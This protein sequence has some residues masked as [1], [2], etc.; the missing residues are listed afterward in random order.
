MTTQ[1]STPFP[2]ADDITPAA[3]PV[4]PAATAARHAYESSV[5]DA[6]AA[7]EARATSEFDRH[8]ARRR[9]KVIA[10]WKAEN[11]WKCERPRYKYED[12]SP[13]AIFRDQLDPADRIPRLLEAGLY[14]QALRCFLVRA[15]GKATVE[16]CQHFL[17]PWMP[18]HGDRSIL[19]NDHERVDL[20]KHGRGDVHT[21]ADGLSPELVKLLSGS[22]LK[23]W[24]GRVSFDWRYD[25]PDRASW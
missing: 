22:M 7:W 21:F 2:P 10:E 13:E 14:D 4:Q 9:A 8:E 23:V 6:R 17:E 20:A 24:L 18:V 12:W 15:G 16:D 1:S 25:H 11:P 5:R 19:P 3:D